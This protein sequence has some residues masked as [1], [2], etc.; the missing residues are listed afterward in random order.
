ML[1]LQDQGVLLVGHSRTAKVKKRQS[2]SKAPFLICITKKKE[3]GENMRIEYCTGNR[4][5][6]DGR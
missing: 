4:S 2:K 3:E 6:R 1:I 5:Y